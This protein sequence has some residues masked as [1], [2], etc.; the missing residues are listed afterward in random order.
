MPRI[1]WQPEQS[2]W[3]SSLPRPPLERAGL[4]SFASHFR[5]AGRGWTKTSSAM[6]ACCRP[7]NSAHWPRKT[8]VRSAWSVTRFVRPGIRSIFRFSSGTQK[9][10]IT[11]PVVPT[12]FTFVFTGMCSSFAVTAPPG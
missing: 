1:W 2:A 7:Q 11:S 5:K 9:L 8:P 10:W 12:T 6:F 4:A 3:K